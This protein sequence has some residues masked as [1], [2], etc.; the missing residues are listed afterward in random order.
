M[1]CKPVELFIILVTTFLSAITSLTTLYPL[2]ACWECWLLCGGYPTPPPSRGYTMGGASAWSGFSPLSP[3]CVHEARA[4]VWGV[5]SP[6]PLRGYTL[7]ERSDWL[8]CPTPSPVYMREARA[9][10]CGFPPLLHPLAT[11]GGALCLIGVSHS[12]PW[13]HT[14]S[15]L[16]GGGS[17]PP[18]PW[19]LHALSAHCHSGGP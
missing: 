3:D 7:G 5:P 9:T 14:R 11:A 4:T 1:C 10:V 8:G 12:I 6:L 15:A 17:P 19:W 13:L 18:P 2:A 16:L